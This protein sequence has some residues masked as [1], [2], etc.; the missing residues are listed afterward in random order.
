MMTGDSSRI[1]SVT[2]NLP[3]YR[4][5]QAAKRK[6]FVWRV[7]NDLSILNRQFIGY[8]RR[9][10]MNFRKD[11]PPTDRG[12]RVQSGKLKRDWFQESVV[13]SGGVLTRIWSTTSYAPVHELGGLFRRN[14]A[15]GRV[16]RPYWVRYTKRLRVGEAWERRYLPE[17]PKVIDNAFA[18]TFGRT[19]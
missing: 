7:Q 9:T 6:A 11:G 3:A 13:R 2:S 19:A 17:M 18:V 15:F 1:F 14:Q 16:T 4:A 10:M 12:T 5:A 8:I